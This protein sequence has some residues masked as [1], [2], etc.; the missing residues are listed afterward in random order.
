MNLQKY[1]N[2]PIGVITIKSIVITLMNWFWYFCSFILS[3]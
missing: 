1:Q 3:F 2:Q